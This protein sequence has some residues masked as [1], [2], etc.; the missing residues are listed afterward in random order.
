MPFLT[1]I[2]DTVYKKWDGAD[3]WKYSRLKTKT[4][5]SYVFSAMAADA[6][7]FHT[8]SKNNPA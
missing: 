5:L 6:Y 8:P 4:R 3:N 2:I 1:Q 7:H